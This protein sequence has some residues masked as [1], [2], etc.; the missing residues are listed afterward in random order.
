MVL[1]LPPR[2]DQVAAEAVLQ[3]GAEASLDRAGGDVTG[4]MGPDDT[5][6]F[7]VSQMGE[8]F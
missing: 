7:W 1:V 2:V 6:V 4:G 3:L 8:P 5:G